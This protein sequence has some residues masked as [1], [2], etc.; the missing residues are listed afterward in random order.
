MVTFQKAWYVFTIDICI[1][2]IGLSSELVH[3]KLEYSSEL[4]SVC[5][6]VSLKK[7]IIYSL[8]RKHGH[9]NLMMNATRLFHWHIDLMGIF[10]D[11]NWFHRQY[12]ATTHSDH[13][14]RIIETETGNVVSVLVFYS[15]LI[16]RHCLVTYEPHG[17]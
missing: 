12:I 2:N 1:N 6:V 3:H 17:Q 16:N 13:S 10:K 5:N 11:S 14:V 15:Y 4:R 9:F 8:R 7:K